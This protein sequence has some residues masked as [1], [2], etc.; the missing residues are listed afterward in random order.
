LAKRFRGEDLKKS[1]NQKKKLPVAVMPSLGI[2]RPSSVVRRLS[3]FNFSHF[4]LLL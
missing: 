4:N 2:R 3:S 1:T